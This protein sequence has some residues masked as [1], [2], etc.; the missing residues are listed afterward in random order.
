M[1]LLRFLSMLAGALVLV[2][3]PLFIFSGSAPTYFD[4]RTVLI[5]M[6]G[7]TLVAGSF[8]FIGFAGG[9]MKKSARVRS[10]GAL[11]L[12]APFTAS[13]AVLWRTTKPELLWLAGLL[14]C[15]TVMLFLSVL[16]PAAGGRRQR[17]MRAREPQLG[18]LARG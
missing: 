15:F 6:L 8:F 10:I 17:S 1:I 7:L 12:A 2:A 5:M 3:P 9:R 11:L 18:R 14:L 4:G 13:V 16:F